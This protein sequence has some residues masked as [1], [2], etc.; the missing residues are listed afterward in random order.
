MDRRRFLASGIA[1]G[2]LACV[3]SGPGSIRTIQAQKRTHPERLVNLGA[4]PEP[5]QLDL[6]RTAVIVVDMQND[7]CSKGGLLHVLGVDVSIVQSVVP[8]IRAV[9]SAARKARL[10]IIY[11]Q[12]A[13]KPDLS[14]LGPKGSPSW[15]TNR[16]AGT[17]NTVTAPNGREG[18]ILI[19]G[20]WNTEIIEELKPE[21]GDIALYKTT[22]SG[23]Y[24]TDLDSTL[25]SLGARFLIVTGCTTSV[26]VES[27]IRDAVFL[28]YSPILLSDCT[29]EP[30]G[31]GLPRSNHEASIF[32][33]Q[34]R[35]GWISTSDQ[36]VQ[37]T[38][39]AH[40]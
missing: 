39:K 13:Y 9:L 25:K 28:D 38:G 2:T 31:Y 18:R 10:K 17:G 5:V 34:E 37:S 35:F 6:N 12:M 29:A 24:Q 36:F 3:E 1:A 23:F 26:C 22:Y 32:I 20:T 19:R 11:L 27:T 7:F 14:D 30:I 33:I 21:P 16:E 8:Q 4:N 15:N 40:A